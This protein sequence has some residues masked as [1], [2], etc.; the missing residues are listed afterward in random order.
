MNLV[1]LQAG[2]PITVIPPILRAEYIRKL[3]KA[4]LDDSE[5]IKFIAEQVLQT[6]RDYLRLLRIP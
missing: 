6:Q 5:F 3:E 2:Y 1:L 4:H